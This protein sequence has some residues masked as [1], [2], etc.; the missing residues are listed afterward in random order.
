MRTRSQKQSSPSIANGQ[1]DAGGDG[2]AARNHPGKY[3]HERDQRQWIGSR[4]AAARRRGMPG[5]KYGLHSLRLAGKNKAG[6]ATRVA[7]PPRHAV[8]SDRERD[9]TAGRQRREDFLTIW[10]SRFST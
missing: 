7:R 4:A 3:H 1:R 8:P 5:S 2:P 10:R 9:D 6:T